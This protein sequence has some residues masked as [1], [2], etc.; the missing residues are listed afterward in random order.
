MSRHRPTDPQS[1]GY[2][3]PLSRSQ[4][5]AV[6]VVLMVLVTAL[7]FGLGFTL[8]SSLGIGSSSVN[9]PTTQGGDTDPGFEDSPGAQVARPFGAERQ[10][11]RRREGEEKEKTLACASGSSRRTARFL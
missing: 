1:T 2:V 10:Q 5:L 7:M 4:L 3:V 6:L 8:V 11:E 9:A